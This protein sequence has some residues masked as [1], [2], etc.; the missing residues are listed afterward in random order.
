MNQPVENVEWYDISVL[1]AQK[2]PSIP[3]LLLFII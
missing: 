2:I 3:L 1:N